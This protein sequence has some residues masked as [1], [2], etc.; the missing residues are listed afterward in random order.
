M[1]KADGRSALGTAEA[2]LGPSASCSCS[3]PGS[4]EKTPFSLVPTAAVALAAERALHG[5]RGTC[6]H[7]CGCGSS[8]KG[9]AAEA[10][11]DGSCAMARARLSLLPAQ[12]QQRPG[13]SLVSQRTL[14]WDQTARRDALIGRTWWL[15]QVTGVCGVPEAAPCGSVQCGLTSVRWAQLPSKA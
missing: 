12:P 13:A 14:H 11:S 2:A 3:H 15:G 7:P 10:L 9:N 1:K 8:L 4:L 5:R 6:Q